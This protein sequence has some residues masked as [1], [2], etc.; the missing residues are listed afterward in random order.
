MV[1][2]IIT[3]PEK[4]PALFSRVLEGLPFA[5]EASETEIR[6]H[7]LRHIVETPLVDNAIVTA[8]KSLKAGHA[9]SPSAG[10]RLESC[11]IRDFG[12]AFTPA[13]SLKGIV[14]VGK[15]DRAKCAWRCRWMDGEVF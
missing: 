13:F 7:R 2:T 9:Y 15:L 8:G 4:V 12:S 10:E 11:Q 5:S 14:A 3:F 1:R 6:V